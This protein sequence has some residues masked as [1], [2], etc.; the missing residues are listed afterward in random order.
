MAT[1]V[2]TGSCAYTSI[3]QPYCATACSAD[4]EA[5]VNEYGVISTPLYVHEITKAA[6]PGFSNSN[7]GAASCGSLAAWTATS[8]FVSCS[9]AISINTTSN[10]VGATAT[11]PPTNLSFN[12]SVP[13]TTN[14]IA[15]PDPTYLSSVSISPSAASAAVGA[16]QQFT[17]LGTYADG[18]TKT[19]TNALWTSSSPG[20]ATIGGGSGLATGIAVG[21]TTITASSSG[22]SGAATLSVTG[23][24]ESGGGGN[25]G[26]GGG[27]CGG[28]SPILIDT[29]GAG[30]QLTSASD[31]VI[32]DITGDG[33][34]IKL[35]WTAR[36][37]RNAFLALDRNGNGK[38]DSGKE[39]F[40]NFTQQTP[41]NDPNGYL[42]LAEFDKPENGGNGDGVI[43]KSDAVF[44]KLLLWIDGNHDGISQPSE[45][46]HLPDLGIY[47][48]SLRYADSPHVDEFGNQFRYKAKV[49][50][51]GEPNKDQVDRTSYDVF[52]VLANKRANAGGK[53]ITDVQCE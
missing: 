31:G 52:F 5:A 25:N 50:P 3:G 10:G 6:N 29:T 44:P 8:C 37:S 21:T 2:L 23:G 51:L 35:S 14:C 30:F 45:L 12:T 11:F 39:L 4:A 22:R 47:S 43:D 17:A 18:S 40:G 24:G 15:N 53:I 26:G 42:A 34:P 28:T 27:N 32:F 16:T 20:V 41:S 19:L 33:K 49:N 1:A 48:L 13:D 46:H 36:G 9:I 7:G 38:I